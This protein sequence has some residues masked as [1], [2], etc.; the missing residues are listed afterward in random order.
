M[1]RDETPAEIGE[2]KIKKEVLKISSTSVFN[3]FR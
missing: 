3:I 2:L 1:G